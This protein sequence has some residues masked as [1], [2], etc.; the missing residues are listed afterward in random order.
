MTRRDFI[1]SSI[2][3]A[4]AAASAPTPAV[5][6]P[7]PS[8]W[9]LRPMR[10]F[11]PNMRESELR[12]FDTARFVASCAA[13]NAGGI[14]VSA[15]GIVAFYPSKVP[16]HYVSPLF[17]GRDFLKE[18]TTQ[19]H[20][21]GMRSIARVDFSKARSDLLR[22]HPDWFARKPDGS[23]QTAGKY[24]SVCPNSP[25]VG[26]AFAIP[27]IREILKGYDVDGFHLNAGGFPGH[28]Y[29]SKCQEKYEARF[30]AKLPSRIDWNDP[31][32]KQ[33]VSWRYESSAECMALLQKEMQAVRKD[34]FW[35][36][37]LAGLDNPNWARDKALDIVRLSRSFSSLM[38]TVD[39][40]AP[41]P[42]LRWVSG[43]TASYD[44]SVGDRP[45]IIN[46]KVSMRSAGWTHASMPPAEYAQCAWQA[47]AHGA[48]LKMP[49]FGLPGNIE[50]ERNMAVIAETLGVLK[51]HAWVYEDA[52][53]AAPVAMVWSQPTLELYGQGDAKARYADCVYGFYAA[54]MENH[55]PAVMVSDEALTSGKL[56]GFRAVVLPNLAC[57]SDAQAQSITEFVR[58]GGALIA[59]HE[60]SLYD[61]AG[62]KRTQL[63]LADVLGATYDAASPTTAARNGYMCRLQP[64]PMT[65]WMRDTSVLAFAGRITPVRL[66]GGSA[67]PLVYGYTAS[68]VDPEEI[69]NPV[70][71]DVPLLIT[72]TF[73]AGK[74]VFLPCDLDRFYF[75]GRLDDARRLLGSAVAWALGDGLPL[76][77]NSPSEVG[78]ALSEKPGFTF[79]HLI[80][81]IGGR[82]LGEVVT[83]RDLEFDVRI[84]ANVKNV[85][86]LRGRATLAFEAR[87][88][89]VR[90]TVPTLNAYE[91][92]VIESAAARPR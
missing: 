33:L 21:A 23:P 68:L 9:W 11:H 29:C 19:L 89:R 54:L 7:D 43:M 6:A 83:A 30:G 46:L 17:N 72:N 55:I 86:T 13:T 12:G 35:T 32:S 66:V 3:L 76:A 53:P 85:R 48:G 4:G 26:E 28:C 25:Y 10:L 91:V 60:T 79:V 77:T 36:G 58:S 31:V 27:V 34:V 38:S 50:D 24:F 67:A 2:S 57:M 81:T 18:V 16:Y 74:A 73:S 92:V 64:H 42:D 90:F 44:R 14:V 45:P 41:D 5:A 1:E 20:A 56:A 84:A 59:S 63:A 39:N 88:G 52:R 65:A 71:T 51:T 69:E 8:Q 80:N 78:V 15:G 75:R 22:D 37:E 70:R 62:N 49:T 87:D 82:P 61:A 47:I 40:A